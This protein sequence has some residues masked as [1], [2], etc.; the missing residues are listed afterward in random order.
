MPFSGYFAI[1]DA[2]VVILCASMGFSILRRS[3]DDPTRWIPFN[4]YSGARW[5]V[6]IA[7][8]LVSVL[9]MQR[10]DLPSYY[11]IS[12]AG[13]L[14]FLGGAVFFYGAKSPM[15]SILLEDPERGAILKPKGLYRFVRHPLFFGLFLCSAGFPLY[16][17]SIPGLVVSIA[18]AFPLLYYSST[19]I[20]AQWASRSGA[21][22]DEYR[23]QVRLFIPSLKSAWKK[24]TKEKDVQRI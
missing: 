3:P 2:I 10:V 18:A 8:L 23:A 19:T 20:D 7:V 15:S 9:T 1:Q 6:G 21:D 16:L 22:Y 12:L 24:E 13:A 11:V 4:K 17:L 5:A 14:V